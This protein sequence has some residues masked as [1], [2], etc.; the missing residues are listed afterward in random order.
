MRYHQLNRKIFIENRRRFTD[1]MKPNS[2]AIFTSNDIYP[3]SAD[4]H[5][6]FK[7]HSDIL[8]LS[9]ADQEESILV[10]FPDAHKN[11]LREVLFLKETN[12][13]I[14][15]WEGAKYTKDEAFD[16]SG[17]KTVFWLSDFERVFNEMAVNAE[18]IYLN[19]NEHL[20]A[21][22]ETELRH[23]RMNKWIKEHYHA[24]EFERS[25]PILHRVRGTKTE[26]E[27][28]VMREAA[29][30]TSKGYERILNFL[31][32]G[33]WEYELEAEFMHEFLMNRSRGFAYTPIIASGNN[34]NVLHYVENNDQC[35][36]G[37]LVLF[38]VGAEYG[39]YTCDV[40]RCYP[41]NGKFTGRQAEVYNAVLSV[42][43]GA[44][45]LLRPG[46]MLDDY[47]KKVGELMTEELL[48]LGLITAEDV[49]NE[50]PAWPAYKKYFMHGTS[51][52]LGL[53]VHDYGLWTIPAEEGMVFT[54]EPGIYIPEE[55]L[56][57]R[58]EDD[59]VITKDG[60]ENMTRSIPKTVEEIEAFM[61]Q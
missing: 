54:V 21:H 27:L 3:T 6:P 31:K 1:L 7:Q 48:K 24:H 12:D 4:G 59:I 40:T 17:I 19:G 13:L 45:S 44:I 18:R 60:H 8:F 33:V 57:I 56:G 38:D 29:T 36:D 25:Q 10:L 26:L 52:Y 14:A 23:D 46:I 53:D 61:A 9:G 47:H 15:V 39:N 51:H 22:V 42:H 55:G 37:D 50:D 28:E 20:R 5:L 58:I 34:A 49:A 11:S 32:P 43:E 35:N 2:L 16:I 41:V 30:I